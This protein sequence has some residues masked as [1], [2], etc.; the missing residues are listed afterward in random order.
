MG[1]EAQSITIGV[2]GSF[3]WKVFHERHP[4]MIEQLCA[5]FPFGAGV[6][7]RL[8]ELLRETTGGVVEPLDDDAPDH[9]AW[10][11]WAEDRLGRPWSECSFLWAESYFFRKLLAAIGYFAPGPW[12]G[13][14]PFAPMKNA[15][16]GSAG[17]A[18]AL[19]AFNELP[20][21]GE[22]GRDDAVVQAAVWGN[23]ADLAFR[24][25]VDAEGAAAG[26]VTGDSL[27][28][29]SLFDA[30]GPVHLVA[31]NSAGELA[32]DLVLVDHLL[33]TGRAD[34]VVLHVK[35]TPY[36]VSDAT[37]ADV[38]GVLR[39]L[40]ELAGE[41]GAIGRRVWDG[42][43]AGRIEV[44]DHPFFCAPLDYR[45]MPY[46][47]REE[48]ASAS[49][50]IMK[51]D[52]NYRRLVGDRYWP[53]TTSFVDVTSY[54]PGPVV[55]LRVLKSEVVVGLDEATAATLD[56]TGDAWR[57]SGSYALIQAARPV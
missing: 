57:T 23:Q 21:L 40:I 8:A 32:A 29:W 12:R 38:L 47:L 46:D 4:A 55:A 30:P 35:P 6:R 43:R 56:K 1:S 54:F 2:P 24:M 20:L 26:L 48:F 18:E 37:P 27:L 52:L 16:L 15:E 36:Y 19:A 9:G 25:S 41:V 42:L 39:H 5:A 49:V 33:T 3:A 22:R 28:F 17:A 11:A 53:P 7:D 51:G 50:T 45:G 14:D 10:A 13:I 31:D 34:R 44:R